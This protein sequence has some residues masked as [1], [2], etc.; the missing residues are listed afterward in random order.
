MSTEINPTAQSLFEKIKRT[1]NLKNEYWSA[2]DL[3]KVLEYSEYR[4]FLPV[5]ERANRHVEIVNSLIIN[6]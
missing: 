6:I 4:H 5:V 1:D 2:R 3:A